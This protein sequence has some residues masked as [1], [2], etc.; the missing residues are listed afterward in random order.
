MYSLTSLIGAYI[1]ELLPELALNQNLTKDEMLRNLQII[2]DAINYKI[3]SLIRNTLYLIDP[4]IRKQPLHG[5]S[6]QKLDVIDPRD[7]C[8]NKEGKTIEKSNLI[9]CYQDGKFYCFDKND[10]V[11]TLKEG[12]TPINPFTKKK[13]SKALIKKLKRYMGEKVLTTKKGHM[14][15]RVEKIPKFDEPF[16]QITDIQIIN[17]YNLT[18]MSKVGGIRLPLRTDYPSREII[19]KLGEPTISNCW[20]FETA[21]KKYIIGLQIHANG[22]LTVHTDPKFPHV[23]K[24]I[25]WVIQKY[26]KHRKSYKWT[27]IS[28]PTQ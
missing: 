3:A 20:Y 26:F 24:F 5:G 7:V 10:L 14:E 19:D 11:S 1:A 22:I 23:K 2:E 18:R 12:K 9:I 25:D 4:S 28:V 13:F 17:K 27:F 21:N 8:A 16:R 15:K 6:F